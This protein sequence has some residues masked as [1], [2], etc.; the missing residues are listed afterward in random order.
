MDCFRAD[1]FLAYVK[2]RYKNSEVSSHNDW[3]NT[4]GKPAAEKLSGA[5][6]PDQI[7]FASRWFFPGLP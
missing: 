7:G 2:S 5:S 3:M 6:A 1:S 4:M